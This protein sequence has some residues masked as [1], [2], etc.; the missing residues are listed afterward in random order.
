MPPEWMGR[1]GATEAGAASPRTAAASS[2]TERDIAGVFRDL[3]GV[4]EADPTDNLFDLGGDSIVAAR[5]AAWLRDTYAVPLETKEIFTNAT[6]AALAAL[7]DERTTT[8]PQ[9]NPR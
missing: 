7:V 6:V 8:A 1:G 4:D 5:L 3:L 2:P 9:E